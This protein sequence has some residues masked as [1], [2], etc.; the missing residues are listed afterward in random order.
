M[1]ESEAGF[2]KSNTYN[3]NKDQIGSISVERSSLSTEVVLL[4]PES[5]IL[6]HKNMRTWIKIKKV[7]DCTAHKET[8]RLAWFV[9]VKPSK[10]KCSEM[11]SSNSVPTCIIASS[12]VTGL[13]NFKGTTNHG[14]KY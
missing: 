3:E 11:R 5:P 7:Q 10:D 13:L 1:R 8:S 4:G 12:A 14:M 9:S 2:V 6:W